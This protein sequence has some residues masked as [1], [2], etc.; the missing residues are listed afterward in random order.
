MKSR[1][2]KY[3]AHGFYL[4]IPDLTFFSL[5]LCQVKGQT[6]GKQESVAQPLPTWRPPFCYDQILPQR[7]NML[8]FGSRVDYRRAQWDSWKRLSLRV[9][10]HA[11]CGI[12]G[13]LF[14]SFDSTFSYFKWDNTFLVDVLKRWKDIYI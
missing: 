7:P 10:P 6:G 12:L 9:P 11:G 2:V 3:L 8:A 14:N 4:L 13:K 1:N 5:F